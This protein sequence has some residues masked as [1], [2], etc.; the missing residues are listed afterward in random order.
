MLDLCPLCS[1]VQSLAVISCSKILVEEVIEGVPTVA[2]PVK[3]LTSIHEDAGSVPEF[4][5]LPLPSLVE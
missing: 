4:Q 3:S 2:Q 5:V 1:P